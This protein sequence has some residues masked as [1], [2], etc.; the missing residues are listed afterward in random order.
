[1]LSD[2]ELDEYVTSLLKSQAKR[3][4]A[5][6]SSVGYRAFLKNADKDGPVGKPNTRFLKNIV[7]DVDGYNAALARKEE[8]ESRERLKDLR[9]RDGERIHEYNKEDGWSNRRS[10]EED[11]RD[12]RKTDR[13]RSPPPPRRRERDTEDKDRWK[14][15]RREYSSDEE[16][17]TESRHRKSNHRRESRREDSDAEYRSRRRR[18]G[19]SRQDSDDDSHR[20]RDH[21]S[22]HRDREK[23]HSNRRDDE[24]SRRSRSPETKSGRHGRRRSTR[25]RHPLS[26]TPPHPT[27]VSPYDDKKPHD[28]TTSDKDANNHHAES[29]SPG[30]VSPDSIGPSVATQGP[31]FLHAKGRGRMNGGTLDAKFSESYDPR[32]DT[33]DHE[34]DSDNKYELD[35][36]GIALRALRERQS[37]ILS[38]AMT[39]RLTETQ[40]QTPTTPSWPT[41]TKGER[42]WDKGKVLL[43]DGSVGV[44]VWG[45]DKPT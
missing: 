33:N 35:D 38:G 29:E 3:Q 36:W 23:R 43:D 32:T 18:E 4:S 6:Y 12:R 41:Y 17:R 19:R 14:R 40:S 1:M 39:E 30:S 16:E 20:H 31:E 24:R 22:R 7:R 37:Y 8:R 25:D 15:P 44:K 45:V 27:K 34:S 11:W 42:E 10:K 9:K 28:R 26:S 13:T 5:A 2:D 21:R